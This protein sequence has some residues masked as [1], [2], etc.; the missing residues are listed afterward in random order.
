MEVRKEP[1]ALK[2]FDE[3]RKTEKGTPFWRCVDAMSGFL[4]QAL[5]RDFIEGA[6]TLLDQFVPTTAVDPLPASCTHRNR[7]ALFALAV[8]AAL[9][10]GAISMSP[11]GGLLAQRFDAAFVYVS[12]VPFQTHQSAECCAGV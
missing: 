11:L 2:S 1:V 3:W 10:V 8:V 9:A 5:L 7:R 12:K 4:L 6:H